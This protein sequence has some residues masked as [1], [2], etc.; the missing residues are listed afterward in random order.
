VA[1]VSGKWRGGSGF[2]AAFEPDGRRVVGAELISGPESGFEDAR[3]QG[4]VR[5]VPL[6]VEL[7]VGDIMSG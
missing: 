1:D 3:S 6:E 5:T 7:G 2:D 4:T